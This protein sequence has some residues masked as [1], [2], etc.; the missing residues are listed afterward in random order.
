MLS[1]VAENLYWISR[2]V[3]RAENTARLLDDAFYLG[4]DATGRNSGN[5][6]GPID[7]VLTILHCRT[8]IE[9]VHPEHDRDSVLQFLTFDRAR[10]YSILAM[11]AR[12]REN[13]RGTQE[14]LSSEAWSQLN[15]LYLYL[16]GSRAQKR[17]R[18][19]P[20]QFY[21][22]LKR[23]CVLFQGLV[24]STLPRSEVYHFLQVGR[25]LERVDMMSRILNARLQPARPGDPGGDAPVQ[26]VQ[27]MSL[28]RSCSA[29]EAYRKQYRERIDPESVVQFLVLDAE[30]PRAIRY[31]IA[32]CVKSLR[33]LGSGAGSEHGSAA[34]RFLGRLDSE[35]HY[36][37]VHELFEQ[38]LGQ[39]L[40]GLQDTCGRVGSE[41]QQAYFLT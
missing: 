5:G 22:R 24:D 31:C 28:L 16:S 19:S 7:R 17:F 34:E 40:S 38:G 15:R 2:Y 20:S 9:Q 21:E 32:S 26:V 33:E 13:A 30:F 10:G 3:E 4:L 14:T 35:L 27:W 1:R 39:F 18:A 25:C 12:A 23:S 36:T 29:Y 37:D 6:R 41:I 11:I 8:A